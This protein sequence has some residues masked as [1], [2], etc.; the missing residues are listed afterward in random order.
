MAL[1]LLQEMPRRD[2]Q[3][4]VISCSA[5]ISAC[6]KGSYWEA[7]LGFLREIPRRSLEP[8]LFSCD[9]AISACE[10]GVQ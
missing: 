5:E 10:K 7:A 3:A 9:A 6:E 4:D 2:L 8:E 1:G